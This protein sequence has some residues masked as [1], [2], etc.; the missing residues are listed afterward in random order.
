MPP[1]L[2]IQD[3]QIHQQALQGMCVAIGPHGAP[4]LLLPQGTPLPGEHVKI[5]T[6]NCPSAF[7]SSWVASSEPAVASKLHLAESN[8]LHVLLSLRFRV[9]ERRAQ[10]TKVRHLGTESAG[11]S[12]SSCTLDYVSSETIGTG[13]LPVWSLCAVAHQLVLRRTLTFPR[14]RQWL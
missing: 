7:D 9:R 12:Q 14:C 1:P 3:M 11:W 8:G 2:S 6:Y 5:N 4:P 13:V 10:I